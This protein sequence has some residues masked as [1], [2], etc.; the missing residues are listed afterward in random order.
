MLTA[1]IVD[2]KKKTNYERGKDFERKVKELF[3]KC[4]GPDGDPRFTNVWHWT[5]EW[6]GRSELAAGRQRKDLGIDLVAQDADDGGLVAI[7]CK[8]YQRSTTIATP[9]ID[10]FISA[11]ANPVFGRRILVVTGRL[12]R[13]ALT[14]IHD[15]GNTTILTEIDIRRCRDEIAGPSG[16]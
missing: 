7:Q 10:S 4:R 15:T 6:P 14:K 3:E 5:D 13:D 9:E 1:E 11:S 8:L 16:Q 2:T 12:H